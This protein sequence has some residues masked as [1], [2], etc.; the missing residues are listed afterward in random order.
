MFKYCALVLSFLL[1]T[2]STCHAWSGNV[3]QSLDG[4]TITVAPMGDLDTPVRVRLYGIDAPEVDQPG[5]TE[6]TEYLRTLLPTGI[7]VELVPYDIDKYNRIV[8]LVMVSGRCV[9]AVMLRAGHAWVY[10]RYCKTSFCKKWT[11]AQRDAQIAGIGL[12]AEPEPVAPWDWRR[13]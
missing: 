3:I 12:W 5:G 6:S 13:Q 4:D 1:E 2:A 10:P 7:D 11:E 9:N 8:A